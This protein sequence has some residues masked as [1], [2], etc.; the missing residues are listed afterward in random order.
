MQ[1]E[2]N[3]NGDITCFLLEMALERSLLVFLAMLLC[4]QH[5]SD[6]ANGA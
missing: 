6:V 2:S 4:D 1:I 5:E 3:Q